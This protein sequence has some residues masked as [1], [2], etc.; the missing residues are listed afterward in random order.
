[1]ES[2][3][4]IGDFVSD[5]RRFGLELAGALLLYGALLAASITAQAAFALQGVTRFA[6]AGLPI[7]GCGAALVVVMR[8]IRQMDELQRRV[9]FEGFAFAFASTALV[10]FGWGFLEMAGAPQLPTFAIWPI[11][12]TFWF[13]GTLGAGRRYR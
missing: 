7:I 8:G 6:L 13:F 9:Q 4:Y 1:M 5:P 3:F 11:M 10:T 12:A 2:S